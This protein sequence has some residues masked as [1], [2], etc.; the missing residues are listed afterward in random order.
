MTL[1]FYELCE[2]LTKDLDCEAICDILGITE[3]DLLSR[4]EDRVIENLDKLQEDLYDDVY[5]RENDEY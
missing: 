2:R 4:F 3:E 1:T 5:D